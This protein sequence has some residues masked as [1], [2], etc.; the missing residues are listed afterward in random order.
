MCE[1]AFHCDGGDFLILT[2]SGRSYPGAT[3]Y[4]GGN[5]V[6]AAVEMAAGGFRGSVTGDLRAEEL[7]QFHDQL[8]DLQLSLR[9]SAQFAT[10]E[11]WLCIRVTGDGRGHM[12]LRCTVRDTSA[13]GN[14]LDCTLAADQTFTRRAVAQLAAAVQAFP[15]I[16]SP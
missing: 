1:V 13:S 15:V 11:G 4:G 5:W 10:M 16:G 7:V 8:A 14:M 3:D 2:L 9:G 6:R 12:E